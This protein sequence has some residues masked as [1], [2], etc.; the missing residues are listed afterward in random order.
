[1]PTPRRENRG[2]EERDP[3]GKIVLDNE[4]PI[5]GGAGGTSGALTLFLLHAASVLCHTAR[6]TVPSRACQTRA[7]A[8]PRFFTFG[9]RS[10]FRARPQNSLWLRQSGRKFALLRCP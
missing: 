6:D 9:F 4:S 5:Q 1:M 7:C 10:E 8:C 3:S 2:E